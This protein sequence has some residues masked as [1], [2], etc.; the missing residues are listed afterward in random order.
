[1][2]S[3]KLVPGTGRRVIS[4]LSVLLSLAACT[5]D[6]PSPSPSRSVSATSLTPTVAPTAEAGE[7]VLPTASAPALPQS[8]VDEIQSALASG[9]A[10]RAQSVVALPSGATLSADA[11]AALKALDGVTLD[12]AT[13][14]AFSSTSAVVD[15]AASGK[16]WI[17]YL[18]FDGAWK[19]SATEPK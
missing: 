5:T 15:G 17:V 2:V 14:H 12:V 11:L 3:S 9:E 7:L 6:A 1:M 16:K 4:A 19:I 18:I 10:A 8:R 13:F